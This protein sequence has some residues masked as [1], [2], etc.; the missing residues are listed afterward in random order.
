MWYSILPASLV[1]I[2]SLFARFFVRVPPSRVSSLTLTLT[3]TTP[4]HVTTPR[5]HRHTD[6]ERGN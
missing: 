3:L 2:E 6:S 4:C 5:L 1:T